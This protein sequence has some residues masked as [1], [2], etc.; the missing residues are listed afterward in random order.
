MDFVYAA[1]AALCWLMAL[2]LAWGC[3]RLQPAGARR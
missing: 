2:G 1:I 3:Q